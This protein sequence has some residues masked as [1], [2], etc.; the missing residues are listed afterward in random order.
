MSKVSILFAVH[1]GAQYLD[2]AIESV[3][4]QE[5]VDWEL[6]A[7]ENGSTDNTY[8]ILCEWS[9]KDTRIKVYSLEERGKNKAYNF[10]FQQSKS[11]YLCFFAADDILHRSSLRSR[12]APLLETNRFDFSTCLLQ[13][14]SDDTRY[15][16]IVY[17]KNKKLPN[18]SGGSILF[19]RT[20]AD[21]VFPI[22]EF[23]PNEDVWT[24]LHLKQYGLGMH[25]EECLYYYRIHSTNSYGY[26]SDFV[27]KRNGF[28]SRMVAFR[29]FLHRYGTTLPLNKIVYLERFSNALYACE[30]ME[31]VKIIISRLPIKDKIL[32]IY[33]C[34]PLLF[35]VKQKIFKYI[36]GKIE[37]I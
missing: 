24:S 13:T 23:L 27:T 7:V 25:V 10:A 36:S 16:G 33:Y 28:L 12:L 1:N 14:I 15:D 8:D 9:K 22:P 29:E 35:S 30:K 18:Y 26:H 31:I 34:S 4:K 32:F 37:L 21:L 20:L 3:C 6:I 19:N 11:A 2:E 5:Y 17:P